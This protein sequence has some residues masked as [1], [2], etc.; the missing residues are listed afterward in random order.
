MNLQQLWEA[1]DVLSKWDH[2]FQTIQAGIDAAVNGD[3][4]MVADGVYTGAGN[5]SLDF[6]GKPITVRS[7]N[8]PENC[9]V[10]CE[11]KGC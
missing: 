5:V 7:E 8:G 11:Y 4:V 9:I 3:V 2:D 10:D 1:L 6:R